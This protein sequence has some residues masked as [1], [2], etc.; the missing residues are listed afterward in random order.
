PSDL[1]DFRAP[2]VTEVAI[3]VQFGTLD[4]LLAPH[5]GLIWA[6]FR[7]QFPEIEE[8]PPL[9]PV[10]ETFSDKAPGLPVPHLELLATLPTPRVFFI[11][12]ARTELLQVQ[13]DRFIHNWRKI[14]DGDAYP[15][16]ERMLETFKAGFL[17]FEAVVT[18]EGLGSIIPNQCEVSY[19]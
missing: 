11:N 3:G 15:R 14:G 16:F 2:P 9:D 18:H 4:R 13:R 5:L 7:D 19:I 10:F 12:T 8:H 1:P 17:K 6:E